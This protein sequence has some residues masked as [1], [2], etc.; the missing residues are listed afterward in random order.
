MKNHSDSRGDAGFMP[1]Q[2]RGT[3]AK[4]EMR[5]RFVPASMVPARTTSEDRVQLAHR[6]L[7]LAAIEIH[8]SRRAVA[9]RGTTPQ[10]LSRRKLSV[11]ADYHSTPRARRD[12]RG[13]LPRGPSAGVGTSD[14]GGRRH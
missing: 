14:V 2:V 5:A 3:E 10:A 9:A 1:V 8:L 4:G 7:A 6:L 12:R 11:A 13:G